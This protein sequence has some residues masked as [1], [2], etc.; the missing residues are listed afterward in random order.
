MNDKPTTHKIFNN[1]KLLT[2]KTEPESFHYE[3]VGE[4]YEFAE[5]KK[6]MYF[7]QE[8]TKELWQ[9][10]GSDIVYNKNY[11]RLTPY[12][13]AKSNLFSLYYE[14]KDT[15]DNIYDSYVTATS[16]G[17][18]Y[19]NLTGSEIVFDKLLDEYRIATH[20]KGQ[21]LDTYGRLRG[22]M[23]YKEDLWEVEIKP[24]NIISKNETWSNP[25]PDLGKPSIA[26]PPILLNTIPPD[27][28]APTIYENQLPNNIG[29]SKAENYFKYKLNDLA[30]D[31][32]TWSNRKETR[33]R[34]KYMKVKI[35]YSGE[36]LAVISSIMTSYTISYS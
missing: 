27:I 24:I 21:N 4:V 19:A 28:T 29:S 5:D 18:D 8:A 9:N 2:N 3:I 12:K 6:T 15:I 20:V 23:Q 7:R 14:R 22:N 17:K 1:L 10:L 36:N 16:A 25:I 31:I 13:N 26:V 32:E 33:I 35:R 11:K 34:D 30:F